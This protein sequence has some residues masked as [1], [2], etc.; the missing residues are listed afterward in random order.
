MS[1]EVRIRMRKENEIA[2]IYTVERIC[3]YGGIVRRNR[4]I[5]E[6]MDR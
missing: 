1:K 5:A 4:N 3:P 2:G 6:V